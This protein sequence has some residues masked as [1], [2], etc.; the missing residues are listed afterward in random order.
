MRRESKK[1]SVAKIRAKK[2]YACA[3]CQYVAG[4]STDLKR[5]LNSKRHRDPKNKEQTQRQKDGALALKNRTYV[6][7]PC[8]K[9]FST[10]HTLKKH[11]DTQHK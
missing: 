1:K 11:T 6:C 5:H 7:E 10:K 8:N 4:S 3:P 2:L 9:P